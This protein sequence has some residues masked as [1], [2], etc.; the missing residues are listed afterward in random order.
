MLFSRGSLELSHDSKVNLQFPLRECTEVW[1]G[2]WITSFLKR[3]NSA[4]LCAEMPTSPENPWPTLV[5]QNLSRGLTLHRHFPDNPSL[6]T[7]GKTEGW[8]FAVN[9]WVRSCFLCNPGIWRFG[10]K[11]TQLQILAL[12]LELWELHSSYL[13]S[14]RLLRIETAT[15]AGSFG[16]RVRWLM[17]ARFRQRA[18]PRD[19]R[20]HYSSASLFLKEL[21]PSPKG[22][23]C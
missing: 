9:S 17:E 22:Q 15:S 11:Q 5:L 1:K 23:Y 12:W 20:S 13:N 16:A 18:E 21:Q 6:V 3:R 19:C 10:I 8:K 7:V 2:Q 14:L 4:V